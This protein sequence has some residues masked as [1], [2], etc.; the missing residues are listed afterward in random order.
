ME[1]GTVE[2]RGMAWSGSSAIERVEVSTDD[3]QTFDAAVLEPPASPH[4]WTPWR[5][6]WNAMPGDHVLAAR[7]TDVT[8][9]I[10]PLEPLWNLQGMAQNGVERIA[11]RVS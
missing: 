10:Q 2:L 5:F 3:R 11:V 9:N 7:A 8:G 6:T 4:T 1:A